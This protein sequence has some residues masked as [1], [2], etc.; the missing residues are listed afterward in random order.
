MKLVLA[1]RNADKVK[2]MREALAGLPFEVASLDA[3]PRVGEIPEE[4]ETLAENALTKAETVA[5]KTGLPALADDTGLEVDALGGRPGVFSSRYAGEDASYEE[6]VRKL[7]L[8][9]TGV[10]PERRVALFRTVV[11]LAL[12]GERSRVVEGKCKGEILSAPR[13]KSGFGYDPVFLP[14]GF[15]RTFAEMTLAEKNAISHRG[16]ALAAARALLEEIA[17]GW[18]GP[19]APA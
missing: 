8:E 16:R 6:N 12:P 4:G 3:F 19:G 18:R 11:A 13:G 2:E 17:G 10:P 15:D 7:L 14:E 5:V 1:T 9:L